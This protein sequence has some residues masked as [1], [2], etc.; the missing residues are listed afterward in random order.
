MNECFSVSFS[1]KVKPLEGSEVRPFMLNEVMGLS[2]SMARAGEWGNLLTRH[3]TSNYC[4]I[5]ST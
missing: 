4:G 1:S 2:L 5:W 3:S